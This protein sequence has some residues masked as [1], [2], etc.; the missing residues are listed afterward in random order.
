MLGRSR[1]ASGLTERLPFGEKPANSTAPSF[2]HRRARTLA[3][4]PKRKVLNE[5]PLVVAHIRKRACRGVCRL[6]ATRAERR[7]TVERFVRLRE[8]PEFEWS[9]SVLS[10]DQSGRDLVSI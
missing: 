7:I 8:R 9:A 6:F 10:A 3:R 2:A 4:Q 5:V 1:S